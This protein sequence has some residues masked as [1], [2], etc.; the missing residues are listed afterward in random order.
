[1]VAERFP[2]LSKL[3]V[4]EKRALISDLCQEIAEA[5]N[6]HPDP[7]IVEI[8]EERWKQHCEDPTGAITLEEFRRRI[9]KD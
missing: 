6:G 4:E 5:D 3:S 7:A 8:L 1:M 2:E 9:G